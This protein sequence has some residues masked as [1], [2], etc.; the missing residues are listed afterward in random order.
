MA[1]SNV[2][3]TMIPAGL[4]KLKTESVARWLQ[5]DILETAKREAVALVHKDDG[6]LMGS[7]STAIENGP[8]GPVG[9]LFAGTNYA[10]W[11]EFEPG[12]NIPGVGTRIRSGGKPYLRPAAFKALQPYTR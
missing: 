12:E 5:T 8:E 4:D 6:D 2:T 3:V 11:Q 10:I 1:V 7:I 9:Y